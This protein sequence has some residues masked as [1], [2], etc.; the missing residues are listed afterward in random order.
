[1][2]LVGFC[3][4][5]ALPPHQRKL[6]SSVVYAIARAERGIAVGCA[7]GA[8]A[9]ALREC[10][11]PTWALRAPM[12]RVFAAFG[13]NGQGD[14]K[15]SATQLVQ[16]VSYLPMAMAGGNG[17]LR[18]VVN[19]WAGGDSSLDLATRLKGR[20]D[21]MVSAVAASGEGQGLVAFVTAGPMQSPGTWRTIRQAHRQGVPV[22]VFN[23][24]CTLR[25][26]P[27]LGEGHWTTA[28]S[29]I[30]GRGWQW[31]EEIIGL[32]VSFR[33][34]VFDLLGWKEARPSRKRVKLDFPLM[35]NL[36]HWLYQQDQK[37]RSNTQGG[38]NNVQPK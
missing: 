1:M 14:G 17:G 24:E 37:I 30:W 2:A 22:V 9:I 34:G 33:E 7:Q 29:G 6:V 15:W 5:R 11:T 27:P 36:R 25:S 20:S 16:Q 10:F 21:A 31:E 26:F 23:C 32:G 18:V 28:G 4:S 19:W 12:V 3:G 35:F 38:V 8:D 13:P